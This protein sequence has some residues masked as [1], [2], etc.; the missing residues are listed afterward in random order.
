MQ[1]ASKAIT[2]GDR[3]QELLQTAFLAEQICLV[4]VAQIA[5]INLLSRVLTPLNHLLPS[6]LLH[7][8]ATSACASLTATFA[9]FCCEGNR[10]K[11][12]QHMAKI[13]AILTSVI[14]SAA[15][16]ALATVSPVLFGLLSGN[17]DDVGIFPASAITF[18]MIGIA[19]FLIRSH[20]YILSRVADL[21]A[22]C[23]VWLVLVLTSELLFGFAR[24]PGSSTVGLTSI[25]TLCCMAMLTAAILIRR[26]ERGLFEVFLAPGMAGRVARIIAPFLLVLPFLR[27]VG[28]A[29]LLNAQLVPTRYATAVLTSAAII[30]SFVLLLL[31]TRLINDM[32]SEIQ[33][34]TLRDELTGLYNFR[35]F[36]LFSEQAFRMARRAKHPF[37]VLFIDM[38]NLKTINDEMGHNAGSALIAETARLLSETFRETDVIGRL[39]GDEFVVAG[40][41]D[42][43]EI[44]ASIERLRSGAET[45]IGASAKGLKLGLS[46]GFAAAEHNLGETVKSI[47]ARADNAMYKEKRQKK[48]MVLA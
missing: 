32:Q 28:R 15:F 31:V 23:L 14:A 7:M 33:D 22:A 36:N 37:G 40:Q 6:G 25:P 12:F 5:L 11:S 20:S 44:S 29:R 3:R 4:V 46:M 39:G 19:I 30:I 45:R 41:F 47:V 26:A 48:R 21:V 10:S 43:E 34:L 8:H 42:S 24:I 17:P 38:D 9:L 13:F 16:V 2:A 35:G 27:E 1:F 18:F